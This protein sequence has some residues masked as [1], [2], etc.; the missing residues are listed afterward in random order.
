L[1]NRMAAMLAKVKKKQC[2]S[3]R[4]WGVK[5][6]AYL[7]FGPQMNAYERKRLWRS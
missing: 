5:L 7:S 2:Y 6:R 3:S 4:K 1:N